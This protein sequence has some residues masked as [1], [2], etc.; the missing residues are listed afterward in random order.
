MKRVLF[1]YQ[2]NPVSLLKYFYCADE[3]AED[4]VYQSN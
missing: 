2:I 3:M 4:A 1:K